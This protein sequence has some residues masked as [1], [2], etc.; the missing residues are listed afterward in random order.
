MKQWCPLYVFLYSYRSSASLAFVWRIHQWPVNS[1][2]KW[3]VSVV[4]LQWRHKKTSKLRV[5]GLCE[6][7]SSVTG[8]FPAQKASNAENIS[9]LRRRRRSNVENVSI[10]WRHHV[11]GIGCRYRKSTHVDVR[12]SSIVCGQCSVSTSRRKKRSKVLGY[13]NKNIH[14]VVI[15]D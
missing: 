3:P 4:S 7:N 2:H 14:P 15:N 6:G 5:T 8:E 1:P 9:I 11:L 13:F 10:W 12:H